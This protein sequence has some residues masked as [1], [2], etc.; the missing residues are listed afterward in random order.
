MQN[1]QKA[2]A[3]SK[4]LACVAT[5]SIWNSSLTTQI[6]FTVRQIWDHRANYIFLVVLCSSSD[7]FFIGYLSL[8]NRLS[9]CTLMCVCI[10]VRVHICG[11][12]ISSSFKSCHRPDTI[13]RRAFHRLTSD[14]PVIQ[15]NYR[16]RNRYCYT[17]GID[18]RQ[19]RRVEIRLQSST[20]MW[21]WSL[22]T[23]KH[24]SPMHA[25]LKSPGRATS[26]SRR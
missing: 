11:S 16:E 12:V 2:E 19:N 18:S 14:V 9:T 25:D 13:V 4:H 21:I 1:K 3:D 15:S 23:H 8:R 7:F 22:N 24:L 10:R 20:A 5:N 6:R 17:L 26:I